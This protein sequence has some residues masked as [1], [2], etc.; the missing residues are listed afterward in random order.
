MEGKAIEYWGRPIA[1]PSGN[2][3]GLYW[4]SLIILSSSSVALF[5]LFPD[6]LLYIA[7][8]AMLGLL[9]LEGP[10]GVPGLLSNAFDVKVY[11]N[12]VTLYFPWREPKFHPWERFRGFKYR[13]TWKG[14]ERMNRVMVLPLKEEGSYIDPSSIRIG[15]NLEDPRPA[16]ELINGRL[17]RLHE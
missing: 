10:A 4:L 16:W 13:R 7:L 6:H 12:G 1:E 11:E 5:L 14:P 3:V 2:N 15:W 9:I 17:P 8:V